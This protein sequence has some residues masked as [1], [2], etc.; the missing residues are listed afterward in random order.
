[1]RLEV[2]IEAIFSTI[3]GKGLSLMAWWAPCKAFQLGGHG[4]EAMQRFFEDAEDS[5]DRCCL[6][7]LRNHFRISHEKSRRM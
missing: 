7:H 2:A 1:M 4:V 5:G 6:P 3:T